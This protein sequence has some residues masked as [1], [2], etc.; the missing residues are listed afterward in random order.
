MKKNYINEV[1]DEIMGEK[2]RSFRL[3]LSRLIKI[4]AF[5]PGQMNVIAARPSVGK[6][7]LTLEMM[8]RLAKS[9][10]ETTFLA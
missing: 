1:I 3:A 2:S 10:V 7:A 8:I 5:E 9:G 6:T 4:G